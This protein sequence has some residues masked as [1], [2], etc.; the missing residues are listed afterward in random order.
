MGF[1]LQGAVPFSMSQFR[2]AVVQE[3]CPLPIRLSWVLNK[4]GVLHFFGSA[5]LVDDTR[6][7]EKEEEEKQ[8]RKYPEKKAG[9]HITSL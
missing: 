7:E 4:A 6:Q 9:N 8:L 5:W 2:P 3:W 1:E